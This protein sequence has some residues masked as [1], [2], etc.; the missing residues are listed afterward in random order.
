[1]CRQGARR[2][3]S[4]GIMLSSPFLVFPGRREG[5]GGDGEQETEERG[6]GEGGRGREREEGEEE[7]EGGG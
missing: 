6:E 4:L 5:G 3:T 1:M 7:K 2:V